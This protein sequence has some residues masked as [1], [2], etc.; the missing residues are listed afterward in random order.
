MSFSNVFWWSTGACTKVFSDIPGI[1]VFGK[2]DTKYSNIN[3]DI[4]KEEVFYKKRNKALGLF[5][6]VDSE[7]PY[8]DAYGQNGN[9]K[10]EVYRKDDT[11]K[12]E[13]IYDKNGN[14]LDGKY[15]KVKSDAPND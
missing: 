4:P 2:I 12:R 11:G 5:T 1:D 13:K 3:T 8:E 9:K 14:K 7:I 10:D 6:K 15:S